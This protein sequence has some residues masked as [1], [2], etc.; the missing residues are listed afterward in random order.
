MIE[1]EGGR[2]PGRHLRKI[3]AIALGQGRTRLDL[4]VYEIGSDLLVVLNG[5]GPHIGAATLA[6]HVVDAPAHLTTLTSLGHREAELTLELSN[7]LTNATGRRT[8]A[9]AGVH[10]DGITKAEIAAIR[11]TV[12]RLAQLAAARLAPA[13][14]GS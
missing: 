14:S 12:R 9:I 13:A 4:E 2:R 1:R 7:T 5:A 3:D 6:E 8:L 10:L 11:R